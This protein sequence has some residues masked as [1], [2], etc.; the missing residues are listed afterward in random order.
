MVKK[1]HQAESN[2]LQKSSVLKRFVESRVS[3]EM[4]CMDEREFHP[5][6]CRLMKPVNWSCLVLSTR[7]E[8]VY[9]NIDEYGYG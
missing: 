4:F 2:A 6:L 8:H 7:Q 1:M 5:S 3:P 9:V